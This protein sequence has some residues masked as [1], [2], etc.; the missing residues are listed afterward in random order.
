MTHQP[1]FET[2]LSAMVAKELC[3]D[4]DQRGALIERLTNA[5]G[6]AVAVCSGGDHEAAERLLGGIDGYL[7]DAVV[8]HSNLA[9]F[10]NT[11]RAKP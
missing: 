10:M 4:A 5:L 6:L 8:E 9:R 3:G 7:A 11:V 1:D 2:K